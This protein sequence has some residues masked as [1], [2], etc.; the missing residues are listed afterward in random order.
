MRLY[1]RQ[2]L[3]LNFLAAAGGSLGRTD[4]QKLLF[5]YL[6]RERDPSYQFVPHKFGGF[7]FQ[8]YA[9]R[10]TLIHKGVLVAADDWV[11]SDQGEQEIVPKTV[12]RIR[13]F[14]K[15]DVP[16]RG[17][18][19]MARV[20]KEAPFLACRSII[21]EEVLPKKE[22]RAAVLASRP[23]EE[24]RSLLSIG[25]EGD[26]IDGYLNRLVRYNVQ[27]L[28]DVRR[29]PLSRKH[30]FSKRRLNE[31]CS[32]IDVA[33][34]HLPELGIPSERRRDLKSRA[35]YDALFAEYREQDL[36]KA[37]AALEAIEV[38]LDAGNRPALTCFEADPEF[39]H[40]LSVVDE[41][42]RRLPDPPSV[43]HI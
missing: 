30:G 39:C 37:T 31:Y 18:E 4:F 40:R 28:V 22:D 32:A 24:G 36:P 2:R 26:D 3:L 34:L 25:Y 9:D 16:E 27:T 29:N 6:R 10:D 8:S 12:S 1:H 38:V 19:L 5:L 43:Q 23:N 17:T 41:L 14:L 42:T 20:Y 13:A 21:I 11:L 7:S 33:Y 15:D 35:D